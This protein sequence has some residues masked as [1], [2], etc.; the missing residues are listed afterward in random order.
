[1]NEKIGGK[2]TTT[3][4]IFPKIEIRTTD[5]TIAATD[6]FLKNPNLSDIILIKHPKIV[7]KVVIIKI[8]DSDMLWIIFVLIFTKSLI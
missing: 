1:M 4:E 8:S 5:S 3:I 7:I 6:D 2:N